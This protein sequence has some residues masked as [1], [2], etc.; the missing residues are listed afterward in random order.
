MPTARKNPVNYKN[1]LPFSET[2]VVSGGN[3]FFFISFLCYSSNA[4]RMLS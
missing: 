2:P 3:A 4:W 1:A